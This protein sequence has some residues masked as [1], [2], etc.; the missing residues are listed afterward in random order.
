MSDAFPND[1]ATP[2]TPIEVI[3][4]EDRA[5]VV[6]MVTVPLVAGANRVV[7]GGLSLATDDTT[8]T[9]TPDPGLE[10]AAAK[11]V[12][13][14]VSKKLAGPEEVARLRKIARD[15]WRELVAIDRAENRLENAIAGYEGLLTTWAQTVARVPRTGRD[16][17]N[18]LREAY[19]AI[20]LAH[21]NAWNE[22]YELRRR[23]VDVD[24]DA[25]AKR[26]AF[27]AAKREQPT[28]ETVVELQVTAPRAG[29]ARL[30]VRYRVPCALWR[31]EHRAI[32]TTKAD[33]SHAIVIK[34]AAVV[35]QATGERWERVR[36]RFST[37][38][39][40]RRPEP[41]TLSDDA[42]GTQ[43][44]SEP[45][46]TVLVEAREESV[47]G[48]SLDRGHRARSEMPGVDDGGEPLSFET[49][50]PVTFPSDGKPLRVELGERSLDATVERVAFPEL[51][52]A[53]HFRAT[54]TL[55]GTSPLLAG[56]VEIGRKNEI[57]GRASVKLVAPGEPFELGFGA[58]DGLRVRR[59]V[60]DQKKTTPLTGTQHV[61]R[62]V[63]IH[64]SN[65][66]GEPRRLL[67][68]ERVP[69]SEVEA[70]SI[71]LRPA[72]GM[73]RTEDGLCPID[74]ELGP[75]DH[76]VVTFSYDLEAG[77]G[78]VLPSF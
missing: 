46:K 51:S 36:C 41:P 47:E 74:V 4:Y 65:L 76:K 66:S 18:S 14:V 68:V 62:E 49:S 50:A 63:S 77:S 20:D 16:D 42:V 71:T 15:A 64:L 43:K 72:A 19:R 58:D 67:V 54:A 5:E 39:P 57:V 60:K 12:R 32:L 11:V 52:P 30:L 22:L 8:L 3:F 28:F 59:V 69:V 75:N 10:L 73:R 37:A 23:H 7:L 78:V 27:D 34:T 35:W 1:D 26:D 40:A 55:T 56:P 45:K 38:R 31:P 2:T 44:R 13:R 70:V 17:A 24:A 53:V 9:V 29:D 33:G 21:R 48:A 25:K 6:R 61:A